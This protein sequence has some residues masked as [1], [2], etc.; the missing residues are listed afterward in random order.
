[1]S[2]KDRT[3]AKRGTRR[4]LEKGSHIGKRGTRRLSKTDRTSAKRGPRRLLKK[5]RT[6]ARRGNVDYQKGIAHQQKG[7]T[8]KDRTSA[9]RGNNKGSHISKKRN[10]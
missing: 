3:S 7:E 6:S 5:D 9:K 10:T 2:K 4:L 8:I 1:M